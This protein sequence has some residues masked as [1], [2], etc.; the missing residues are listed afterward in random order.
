MS[1]RHDRRGHGDGV[2]GVHRGGWA[3]ARRTISHL[4]PFGHS[5]APQRVPHVWAH[6]GEGKGRLIVAFQPTGTMEVFFNEMVQ[7]N[8][9]SREELRGLFASHGMEVTGLPWPVE[10]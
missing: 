5:L 7:V 2:H 4:N 10:D 9:P 8:D 1:G 6:V 3:R